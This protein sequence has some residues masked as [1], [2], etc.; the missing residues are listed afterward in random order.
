MGPKLI[1]KSD[2][3]LLF[4]ISKNSF[5]KFVILFFYFAVS[6]KGP[7]SNFAFGSAL[8]PP[9]Y[10]YYIMNAAHVEKETSQTRKKKN[11][12]IVHTDISRNW[13]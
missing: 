1:M 6:A 7:E 13:G 5:F 11:K 9:F 2:F 8:P 4:T 10:K 3:I 12:N